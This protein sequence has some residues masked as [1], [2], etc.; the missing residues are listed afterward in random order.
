VQRREVGEERE[1]WKQIEYGGEQ[2]VLPFV[3][4]HRW[5]L[6][7]AWPAKMRLLRIELAHVPAGS[8]GMYYGILIAPSAD[9][10]NSVY[11]GLSLEWCRGTEYHG[12]ARL[13]PESV[14]G[15]EERRKI[16]GGGEAELKKDADPEELIRKYHEAV[17]HKVLPNMRATVAERLPAAACSYGS[18]RR[19]Q[20]ARSS[21]RGQK[22]RG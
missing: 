3:A 18:S 5:V 22:C 19:T 13:K 15:Q 16:G 6:P 21:S 2:Q 17:L 7:V 14:K 1:P 8:L 10:E 20:T 4:L 11:F 9:E 12:M